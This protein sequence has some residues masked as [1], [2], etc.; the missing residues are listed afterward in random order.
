MVR[1]G[2]GAWGMGKD[3]W[4]GAAGSGQHKDGGERT[5]D[6]GQMTPVK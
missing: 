6:R 3:S 1:V 5:D 2:H 4:Q